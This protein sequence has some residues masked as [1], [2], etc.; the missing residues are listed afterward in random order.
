MRWELPVDDPA[1]FRRQM[2]TVCASAS[3]RHCHW[4]FYQ[5]TAGEGDTEHTYR[6]GVVYWRSEKRPRVAS[7]TT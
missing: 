6:F 2:T 7:M 4:R 1:R 3:K 5:T